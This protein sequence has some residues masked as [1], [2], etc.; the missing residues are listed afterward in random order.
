MIYWAILVIIS[1]D[2]QHAA[3]SMQLFNSTQKGSYEMIE[4]WLT[5]WNHL[6]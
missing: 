3:P 2:D 5:F 4:V 1:L 6:T